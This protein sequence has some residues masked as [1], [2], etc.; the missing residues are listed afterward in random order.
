MRRVSRFAAGLQIRSLARKAKSEKFIPGIG[1]PGSGKS[2]IAKRIPS[3]LPPL[4]LREA[5]ETLRCTLW[6]DTSNL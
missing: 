6:L 2:M 3:I 4:T 5:I 1:P